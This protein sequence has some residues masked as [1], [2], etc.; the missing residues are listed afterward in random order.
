M[1]TIKHFIITI[2]W[3]LIYEHCCK[4]CLTI[5]LWIKCLQ[6]KQTHTIIEHVSDMRERSL[7]HQ[8]PY[9][10]GLDRTT[11]Y[12]T[13][14]GKINHAMTRRNQQQCDKLLFWEDGVSVGLFH[15]D[16]R[17]SMYMISIKKI[18]L[19]RHC[20]IF[21]LGLAAPFIP[22]PCIKKYFQ[23]ISCIE[24]WWVYF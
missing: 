21:I 19:S 3:R 2:V 6:S 13:W 16:N 24:I 17:L 11:H 22:H 23:R 18:R 9:G 15:Y 10:T 20:L 5:L 4:H 7:K 12:N 8:Q 14:F 1:V